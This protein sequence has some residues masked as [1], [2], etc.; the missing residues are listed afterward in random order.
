MITVAL[1]SGHTVSC[2][3]ATALT[4][5][6]QRELMAELTAGYDENASVANWTLFQKDVILRYL[7]VNWDFT[8]AD[9][10]ALP[11]PSVEA[12]SWDEITI[13]DSNAIW[14]AVKDELPKLY[15]DFDPTMETEAT[16]PKA[17]AT[18]A[19]SQPSAG[20]SGTEADTTTAA[21]APQSAS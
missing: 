5:R 12:A 1:P 8:N 13:G 20:S 4:N 14:V 19:S 17:A 16:D 10:S 3:E 15:P 9:G 21:P 2:R 11:V 7:I 6:Q 18:T